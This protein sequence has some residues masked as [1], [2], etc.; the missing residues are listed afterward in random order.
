MLL[1]T[2]RNR[3]AAH[4]AGAVLSA[5]CCWYPSGCPLEGESVLLEGDRVGVSYPAL[6]R[7]VLMEPAMTFSLAML[8]PPP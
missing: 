1:R 5:S 4:H 8:V 6:F 2:I 7:V 3:A